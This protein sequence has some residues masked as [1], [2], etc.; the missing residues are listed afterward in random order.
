M[1][2]G[3]IRLY[4]YADGDRV[5][6]YTVSNSPKPGIVNITR[7]SN[8]INYIILRTQEKCL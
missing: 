2:A 1:L 6:H 7:T 5:N 8:V 3:K 4:H